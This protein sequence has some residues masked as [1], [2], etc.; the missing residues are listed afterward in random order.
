MRLSYNEI[1]ECLGLLP[2]ADNPELTC[3]VTDSRQTFPGS[4]FVCI[5][6]SRADGHAFASMAVDR[7]A[8][9][10]LVSADVAESRVPVLR[11]ADT[12]RA[13]GRIAALW[14]TRT[15]ARVVGVTGTAGKTTVKEVLSGVLSVRGRTA[16]NAMNYNNQIGMPRSVLEADGQ[17]D[18]WVMELGISH[19]GDMDELASVL[20][21][22]M[23]LIVNAGTGHAEGLGA[24]G[25]AWHKARLLAHLADC[26]EGLV[27]A[28]YPDLVREAQA[29]G[30]KLHL[31]SAAGQEAAYCASYIGPVGGEDDPDAPESPKGRYALWLGGTRH[32]VVAPF[33]GAYGAE[34][35]AATGAAA[36][37]LGLSPEEIA[38]GFRQ[39]HLPPQRFSQRRW[40]A[41][42][43]MD[44]TYN[45]NPLSMR[46][47]L[48]AAAE[49]AGGRHFVAVLGEMLELGCQAESEHYLLGRNLAELKPSAVF[50][51]GGQGAAVRLG[52]SEGGYQGPWMEV[53]AAPDFLHAWSEMQGSV[54]SGS[55][56]V[57]L[58]KGSRSTRVED[59]LEIFRA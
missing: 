55:G 15:R 28:D 37:L 17:E 8:A 1:A 12:V 18:F 9:A 10:L 24:K 51:K 39:A 7:G 38:T 42:L 22:D 20:R 56:G 35:V 32:E 52:L 54:L 41:W 44:D 59:F 5:P 3:A 34:N 53:T 57:V 26:G 31:F 21:P 14:R 23:G 29:T 45:A 33:R 19:D 30:A 2:C 49:M 25:V 46:R 27:C 50:W 11:V 36:F 48:A 6:G 43:L 47:M 58:F 13:L 16:Q 4:L 40:G